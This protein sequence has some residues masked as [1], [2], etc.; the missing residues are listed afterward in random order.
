MSLFAAGKRPGE[1][2]SHSLFEFGMTVHNTHLSV[3]PVL[4]ASHVLVKG[5]LQV[6]FGQTSKTHY[7]LNV[8]VS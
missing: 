7:V 3:N 8:L 2:Y 6:F 1:H 5:F 4:I